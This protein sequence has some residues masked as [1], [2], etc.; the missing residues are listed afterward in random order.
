MSNKRVYSSKEERAAQE[1]C[2]VT[3]K[4]TKQDTKLGIKPA[5][6]RGAKYQTIKKTINSSEEVGTKY[7]SGKDH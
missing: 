3:E 6:R 7:F 2:L 4:D 1:Y 5:S